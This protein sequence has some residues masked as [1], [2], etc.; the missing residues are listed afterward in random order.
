MKDVPDIRLGLLEGMEVFLVLFASL[1]VGRLL[2]AGCH[3]AVGLAGFVFVTGGYIA[4]S[5]ANHGGGANQ[6][7]YPAVF[8]ATLV[9]S[10]GQGCFFI[11]SSQNASQWFPKRK[12]LVVGIT[13]AGAAFG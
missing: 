3:Y 8:S 12:F 1:F 9:Y 5:F 13:S 2:D 11:Y 7:I 10:L 6:G 4:L